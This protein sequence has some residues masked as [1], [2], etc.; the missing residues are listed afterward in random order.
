M[1]HP[2]ESTQLAR[3]EF[4]AAAVAMATLQLLGRLNA[5]AATD[6]RL[7][8]QVAC[9]GDSI[10]EGKGAGKHACWVKLVGNALRDRWKLTNYGA[11]K[12]GVLKKGGQ[13]YSK[14][15][16]LKDALK[17][18]PD[19]AVIALGTHDSKPE[20]WKHKEDF[21]ADY[22]ALIA[23]IRNA[24]P[25]ARILCCLP[26]PAFPGNWGI[27]DATIKNEI[28]PLIRQVAKENNCELVDLYTPLIGLDALAP[29]RVH[30]NAKGHL[31]L[32]AVIYRALTSEEPPPGALK[33]SPKPAPKLK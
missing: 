22:T 4:L 12:A 27:N 6:P 7:V 10:T 9:L 24:S 11:G 15:N 25:Q 14:Q 30:P 28:I 3:R 32:A 16:E 1:Q 31:L 20:N 29:D 5:F 33:P 17:S 2:V 23:E 21:L 13:P 18:K 8:I 26:P 19:V